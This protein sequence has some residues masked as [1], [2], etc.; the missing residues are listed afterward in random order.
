MNE[1]K[2]LINIDNNGNIHY[3]GWIEWTHKS[4]GLMHCPICLVLHQC[5]F[6]NMIMPTLPIHKKCHCLAKPISSPIPNYN[7]K[8]T[9]DIKK[10]T[11]YIFSDKYAWNGKRKLF[12]LLGFTIKDTHYLKTE[13]EKQSIINYCN[14]NYTLDKLDTQGQRININI[15]FNKN[16]K[17][18]ILTSGWMIRPKGIITNNTPL[19][20]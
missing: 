3:T 13:Y 6:N 16:E 5:W 7:S 10:F 15:E 9:C 8:A 17:Y 1:L 12:E 4:I 20:K 14:G 11:D 18:V 2:N 19:A